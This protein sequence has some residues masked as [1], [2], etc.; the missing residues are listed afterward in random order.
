MRRAGT[1]LI[2]LC[3]ILAIAPLGCSANREHDRLPV[4][5]RVD[6]GP[7]GKP[8]YE[9]ALMVDAGSTPK[10]LVSVAFPIQ[11]GSIC[12]NT[13]EVSAIDGVR[14]EPARNRWWTCRL[15]GSARVSPHRTPLHRGD[16][17]EWMFVE[18]PQ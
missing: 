2:C 1:L 6:F 13:R 12:C 4:T 8:A 5:L 15:N 9:G 18:Q 16:R 14:T 7:V 17:V 11:S 10:D 3:G